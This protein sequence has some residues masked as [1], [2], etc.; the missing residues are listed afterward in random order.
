MI[1]RWITF[2]NLESFMLKLFVFSREILNPS[3]IIHIQFPNL[4]IFNMDN[5]LI[6]NLYFLR[7]LKVPSLEQLSL[8]NNLITDLKPFR[9]CSFMKLNS[10]SIRKNKFEFHQL[11]NLSRLDVSKNNNSYMIN[12]SLKSHPFVLTQSLPKLQSK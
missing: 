2:W 7:L 10:L 3:E 11:K 5:N 1:L 12:L 4:K 8:N 6:D 9:A